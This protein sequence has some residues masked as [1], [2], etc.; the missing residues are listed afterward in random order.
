MCVIGQVTMAPW[1]AQGNL[2]FTGKMWHRLAT[3]EVTTI[4]VGYNAQN[5]LPLTLG[6]NHHKCTGVV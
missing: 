2:A 3:L 1:M 6:L 5:N 4:A